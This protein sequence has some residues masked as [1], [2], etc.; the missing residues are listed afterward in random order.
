MKHTIYTLTALLL[1]ACTSCNS[2]FDIRSGSEIRAKDHYNVTRGFRQTLTGCYISMA[3]NDLYGKS[4]TWHALEIMAHQF[5]PTSSTE[6]QNL[7]GHKLKSTEATRIFQGVWDKSYNTIVNANDALRELEARKDALDPI[8]YAVIKGELLA[9]RGYI[10][11]DLLRL[12]GYGNWASRA[13]ELDAKLTIPYLKG[14]DRHITDQLSGADTYRL[15]LADLE[16]AA[17]LLRDND[18]IT[19]KRPKADYDFVNNDGDYN[20][21]DLFLNYY[22]VKALQARVWLWIGTPEAMQNALVAANE[23]IEFIQSGG[24]KNHFNT[25][26]DFLP[27]S[28][29]TPSNTSMIREALFALDVNDMK[30]S[31]QIYFVP[32]FEGTHPTALFQ[33]PGRVKELFVATPLDVRF[34]KL[35]IQNTS[36]SEGVYVPMKFVQQNLDVN[37]ANRIPLIRI[38]EVYYI[39]A[40]AELATKG[41]AAL[42]KV[43]EL[44]QAVRSKRGVTAP[45]TLSDVENAKEEIHKEYLKEYLA[46]GV[47]FFY[48]KRLG[49]SDIPGLQESHM[50][51][52]EYVIPYPTFEIQNGRV[53]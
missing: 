16:E 26:I 32:S 20:D 11:F 28:Q 48:Y 24:I 45:L 40:E 50:T 6:S 31:T 13:A 30:N 35:L 15:I 51:D 52:Q 42:G 12:Y 33:S 38:P 49:Y 37:H 19:Q 22:A 14:V 53:Q 3:Q 44:L 36:S 17:T 39:A 23:V 41:S 43:A 34:T 27:V 29:L 4:L 2:W 8:D 7:Y 10:H 25:T 5:E 1:V 18:P 21:R 46:E 9:I 47:M